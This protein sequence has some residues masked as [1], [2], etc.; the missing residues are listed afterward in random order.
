M[1]YKPSR[2]Q[3]N[4][5]EID[6]TQNNTFTCQI[7]SMGSTTVK[8]YKFQIWDSNTEDFYYWHNNIVWDGN[9]SVEADKLYDGDYQSVNPI[10]NKGIL[11]IP[12]TKNMLGTSNK[13]KNG[14]NFQW[15]VRVYEAPLGSTE[16]PQ[17]FV[18]SGFL[19]GSTRNVIWI[20][21]PSI[22]IEE[23]K[24]I[25]IKVNSQ[26]GIVPPA[27]PNS[28]N[29][30]YPTSY[31]YIE[32]HKIEFVTNEL[33]WFKNITKLE[34]DEPF[35]YNYPDGTVFEIYNCSDK[36]TLNS[37]YVDPN[38]IIERGRYI[39]INNTSINGTSNKWRK[40]IG[41][42][43]DTGEIRVQ[44]AFSSVPTNGVTF[45]IGKMN[46]DN[47]NIEEVANS[48]SNVIGGTPLR[49]SSSLV[50]MSNKWGGQTATDNRLFIQPN[51]NI[52]SDGMNP[53]EIVFDINGQIVRV[54]IQRSIDP[55]GNLIPGRKVVDT[56][57]DKLDNTQWLLRVGNLQNATGAIPT[58]PQTSYQ[59]FTDFQDAS[60]LGYFYARKEPGI[61]MLF[62]NYNDVSE[63][64]IL[65]PSLSE[66]DKVAKGWPWRDI[67]FVTQWYS[68]NNVQTKYY[69]YKLYS[70]D[71][72]EED[73]ELITESE[74]KYDADYNWY[75]RGFQTPDNPYDAKGT[76]YTIEIRIVDE[77]NK[78]FTA[79][80]PFRVYYKVEDLYFPIET[81]LDCEERCVALKVTTPAFVKTT[82][83]N[84]SPYKTVDVSNINKED[85]YLEIPSGKMLNYTNLKDLQE[86]PF[87]I[88][89][90]FAFYTQ[91][92]IS[93]D[94]ASHM[95][96]GEQSEVFSF[97]Y[98]NQQGGSDIFSLQFGGLDTFYKG[99]NNTTVQTNINR[100]KLLIYINGQ[101]AN[102]IKNDNGEM[103]NY[104]DLLKSADFISF[105]QIRYAVQPVEGLNIFNT[106]PKIPIPNT[107]YVIMQNDVVYNNQIYQSGPYMWDEQKDV[108]I[109]QSQ[110]QYFFLENTNN[111]PE[112]YTN[113]MLNVPINCRG[114]WGRLNYADDNNCWIDNA[115]VENYN[116]KLLN[117]YWFEFYFVSK[118]NTVT[119][120]IRVNSKRQNT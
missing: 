120:E 36:H 6:I 117:K 11:E 107:V 94:F 51:I 114:T 17:T 81:K 96:G 20:Q 112:G 54:D 119:C 82:D 47:N 48:G 15:G 26:N 116:K 104:I 62:K 100:F 8:A 70:G 91:F 69:Q 28:E 77:Y 106:F 101:P 58:S 4:I 87:T 79:S 22:T 99:K 71:G 13:M 45:T 92:Q 33:G 55:T 23:N 75:F 85:K 86:S 64:P 56:T 72:V 46:T 115:N 37:V 59:V 105:D 97:S 60:P 118:G 67:Y 27:P 109:P 16:Q 84:I 74:E 78:E 5:S 2:L 34:L 25:Q 93:E 50:I 95:Q 7:N 38:D 76:L 42:G 12:V 108:F 10:K 68:P 18:C 66:V 110:Y 53:D 39:K 63:E 35:I 89:N 44:E 52:K 49:T 3:P 19:V 80:Y 65:I 29:I 9:S 88:P 61:Q 21:N 14:R 102:L 111:A 32:R 103:V 98:Q 113:D 57:F 90:K 1:L 30:V 40:I 41:Y 24:Y 43:E 31:P 83:Y 73:L